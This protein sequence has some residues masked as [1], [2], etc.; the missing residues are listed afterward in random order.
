[1]SLKLIE[2]QSFS[3]KCFP[4]L[5]RTYAFVYSSFYFENNYTWDIVPITMSTP[6]CW[7]WCFHFQESRVT[8]KTI[9][10]YVDYKQYNFQLNVDEHTFKS[11]FEGA[12]A[13]WNEIKFMV[14]QRRQKKIFWIK[15]W[16]LNSMR[17]ILLIKIAP[18]HTKHLVLKI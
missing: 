9:T 2:S 12:G 14:T 18:T 4:F 16:E 8:W 3:I 10:L 17:K 5:N 6:P 1:M 11:L 7:R 15:F 13:W